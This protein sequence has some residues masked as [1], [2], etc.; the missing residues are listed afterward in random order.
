M[1]AVGKRSA[2]IRQGFGALDD[3]GVLN[4]AM[5]DRVGGEW[6]DSSGVGGGLR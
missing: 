2:G 3:P 1:L 5:L 6:D 4:A